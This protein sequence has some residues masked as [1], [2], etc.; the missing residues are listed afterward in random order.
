M[1]SYKEYWNNNIDFI[2]NIIIKNKLDLICQ[3]GIDSCKKIWEDEI[4]TNYNKINTDA[5]I[6]MVRSKE[7]VQI[8]FKHNEIKGIDKFH[9]H[10]D[11]NK[12]K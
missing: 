11:I 3:L 5:W 10:T 12:L 6:N 9:T 2:G 4:N 7:P 1:D 8:Q